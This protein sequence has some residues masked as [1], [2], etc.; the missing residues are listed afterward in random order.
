MNPWELS[1]GVVLVVAIVLMGTIFAWKQWRNLRNL[2][3]RDD[4]PKEDHTYF[5][6]RALRRF[7]CSV[8]MVIVAGLL[9]GSY[10]L[11]AEYQKVT[12]EVKQRSEGTEKP[13]I[14]PEEKDFVRRFTAY[15]ITA[16]LFLLIFAVLAAI[17][18]W[19]TLKYGFQ[20]HRHLQQTH[21]DQL[22]EAV[23]KFRKDRN[24]RG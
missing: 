4:L 1:I 23:Q 18:I 6:Q 5:R 7:F 12:Q 3:N 9:A 11:E 10:F 24:G 16:L 22:Q 17:D 2:K 14:E 19:A 13:A 21:R 8:V 20:K 15:W